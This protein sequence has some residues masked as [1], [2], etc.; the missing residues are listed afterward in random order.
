MP[1]PSE[2]CGQG[3]WLPYGK[4]PEGKAGRPEGIWNSWG[5]DKLKLIESTE[6]LGPVVQPDSV[7]DTINNRQ[8]ARAIRTP[9]SKREEKAGS[10]EPV[11]GLMSGFLLG[12]SLR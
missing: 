11:V 8:M 4:T 1:F 12:K 2:T 3:T 10:R 6:I 7:A 5:D 9:T